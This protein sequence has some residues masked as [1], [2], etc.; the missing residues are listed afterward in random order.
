MTAHVAEIQQLDAENEEDED[1]DVIVVSK[2]GRV[3]PTDKAENFFDS[4]AGSD[5]CDMFKT[6]L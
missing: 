5:A 2:E 6:L 3:A 1:D 4:G